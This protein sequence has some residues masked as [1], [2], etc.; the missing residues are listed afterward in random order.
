MPETYLEKYGVCQPVGVT[1]C[2]SRYPHSGLLVYSLDT[3]IK[4]GAAP[5]RVA[6]MSGEPLLLTGQ[7]LDFEGVRF[8]VMAASV[9][10]IFV[11]VSSSS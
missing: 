4:H 6:Q 2:E 1:Q 10:S 11:Q 5:F 8:R 3:K 9:N 7:S